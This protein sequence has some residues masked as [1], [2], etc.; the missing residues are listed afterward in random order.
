MRIEAYNA[1]SQIYSAKKPTK[2][3]GTT[4]AARTDQVSISSLGRDM[5]TVRQAVSGS[6][7]IRSEITDPLKAKIQ[8]GNY[9]VSNDDFAG[10]LLAKFE[11]KFSF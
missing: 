10:K 8:S 1:M 11:E 6:S 5:Q 4:A 3:S 9:S 7:D 2:V